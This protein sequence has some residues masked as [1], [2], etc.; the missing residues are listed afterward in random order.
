M[1][2]DFDCCRYCFLLAADCFCRCCCFYLLTAVVTVVFDL[3]DVLVDG[4][5][6]C[7]L[8]SFVVGGLV[9]WLVITDC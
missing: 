3:V 1:L 8:V 9:S 5:D 7:D 6:V 2:S 4:C